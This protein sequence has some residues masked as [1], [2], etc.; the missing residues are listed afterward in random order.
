MGIDLYKKLFKGENNDEMLNQDGLSQQDNA[1]QQNNLSNANST[2]QKEDRE[3]WLKV[4]DQHAGVPCNIEA[5]NKI[6]LIK[7]LYGI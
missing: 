4:Y 3:M 5:I 1:S 7:Q 2:S 6:T